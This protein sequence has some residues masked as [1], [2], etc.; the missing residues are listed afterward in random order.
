MAQV[1]RERLSQQCTTQERDGGG[2]DDFFMSAKDEEA[3]DNPVIGLSDEKTG[4]KYCRARRKNGAGQGGEM[5]WLIQDKVEKFKSWGHTG[6][7]VT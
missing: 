2:Q 5:D 3:T 6:A 4:E 7:E 1:L